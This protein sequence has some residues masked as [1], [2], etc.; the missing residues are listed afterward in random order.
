VLSQRDGPSSNSSSSMRPV[1]PYASSYAALALLFRI[2]HRKSE[3][4]YQVGVGDS[5]GFISDT[6]A[7]M[8]RNPLEG[9]RGDTGLPDTCSGIGDRDIN[10]TFKIAL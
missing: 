1:R 4:C 10:G 9:L 3:T 5:R 2:D 7:C 6:G 8:G